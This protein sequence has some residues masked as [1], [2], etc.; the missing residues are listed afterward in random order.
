MNRLK[1][2]GAAGALVGSAL[3]GGTLIS[4]ALAAPEAATPTS[5]ITVTDLGD[6]TYRDVYLDALAAELGVDRSALGPAAVAAAEAA[7]DAAEDAG[8]I[9]ADRAEELRTRL[10]EIADPER[11]LGGGLGIRLGPGGPGGHGHAFRIGAGGNVVDAAASAL[12]MDIDELMEALHDGTSLEEVAADQDVSYD[13]V[14]T[15]VTTAMT[16]ALS[17]AVDDGAITQDRADEILSNLQ[18]WLDDGGQPGA[19]AF[20]PGLGR[21]GWRG[22]PDSS[23]DSQDGSTDSSDVSSS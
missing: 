3:I 6:G 23:D 8:D 12:G 22:M 17:T 20:G 11:L 15:A 18:A 7:I 9:S 4:A 14:K 2:V 19:G 16:D 5:T 1:T 21:H 10:S 13:A